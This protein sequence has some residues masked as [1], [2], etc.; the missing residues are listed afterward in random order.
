MVEKTEVQERQEW[1]EARCCHEIYPYGAPDFPTPHFD[2]EF[3]V[4]LPWILK[5]SYA[6]IEDY[7]MHGREIEFSYKDREC[8]ITNHSKCWWFY[9]GVE[10]IEICEFENFTC[11]VNQIAECVVEDK[12]VQDIFDN[13]LY[14]DVCIW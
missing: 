6:D 11:L 1:G 7:L 4:H 3:W 12:T 8:A 5:Y 9:D 10:Q 14:E 13:G 2:L